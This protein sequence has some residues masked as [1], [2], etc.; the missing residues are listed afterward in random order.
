MAIW[1]L[2]RQP[3]PGQALAARPDGERDNPPIVF[4]K[5]FQ[6]G[7][8]PET[9]RK[10]A[11]QIGGDRQRFRLRRFFTGQVGAFRIRYFGRPFDDVEEVKHDPSAFAGRNCEGG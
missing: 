8:V 2:L 11:Q 3:S 5:Y 1:R 6:N 10:F 4:G 9:A 7:G